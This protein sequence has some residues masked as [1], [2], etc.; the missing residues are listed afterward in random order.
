MKVN[1]TF[2]ATGQLNSIEMNPNDTVW[3]LANSAAE[4]YGVPAELAFLRLNNQLL[5][6]NATL[7]SLAN[8]GTLSVELLLD[9]DG[10]YF[11]FFFI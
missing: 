7:S 2:T 1:V 11:C 3:D 6:D 10:G 4:E 9:L 5:E 8:N